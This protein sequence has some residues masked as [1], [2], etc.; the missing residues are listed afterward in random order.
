MHFLPAKSVRC[1]FTCASRSEPILLCKTE[2][3]FPCPFKTP[4][5]F[6]WGFPKIRRLFRSVLLSYPVFLVSALW[7]RFFVVPHWCGQRRQIVHVAVGTCGLD[8]WL[9]IGCVWHKHV[10]LALDDA[11]LVSGINMVRVALQMASWFCRVYSS[12]GT[13]AVLHVVKH[14]LVLVLVRRLMYIHVNSQHRL[15]ECPRRVQNASYVVD[16]IGLRFSDRIC[17]FW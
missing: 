16:S 3:C 9:E 8:L 7:R 4:C 13:L 15:R 2:A 5:F 6:H 10:Q 1:R 12:T 14:I 17:G 11:W